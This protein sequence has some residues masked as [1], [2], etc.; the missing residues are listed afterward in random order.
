MSQI[1]AI[2]QRLRALAEDASPMSTNVEASARQLKSLAQQVES[3]SRSGVNTGPL[4]AAI[5]QAQARAQAAADAATQVRVEGV[6]WANHLA[7]GG[8]SAEAVAAGGSFGTARDRAKAA[9]GGRRAS[10]R[11]DLREHREGEPEWVPGSGDTVPAALA[12]VVAQDSPEGWAG[13]I[14]GP[15][16]SAPGRNNNCVDCSRAVES[17]FR[18]APVSSAAMADTNAGGT[19]PARITS[20]A[21][22]QLMS[23]NYAGIDAKLRELGEGS[24]AIVVSSWRRGGGHAFNAINDGGVVKFVDGQS[25]TVSGWPPISWNESITSASWAV[26]I[27]KDGNPTRK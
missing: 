26:F 17:T 1:E 9:L 25:G 11:D 3:L 8:A 15:G 4:L 16:S 22:G 7:R 14:N 2:A 10:R 23:T 6:F 24:S 20:W 5:Q 19:S 27:D 21:G 12:A 13:L 18:G